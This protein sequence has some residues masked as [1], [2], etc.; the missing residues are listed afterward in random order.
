MDTSTILLALAAFLF[1]TDVAIGL[2]A[3]GQGGDKVKMGNALLL[4]AP[5]VSGLL[6]WIALGMEG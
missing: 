4:S 3:R 5:L 2:W 1:V 6:V